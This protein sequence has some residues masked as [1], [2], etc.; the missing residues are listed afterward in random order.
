MKFDLRRLVRE[1]INAKPDCKPAELQL[2]TR[3]KFM[4]KKT[5]SAVAGAAAVL[6]MATTATPAMA[7]YYT[8]VQPN[9]W[10]SPYY[11]TY[12]PYASTYVNPYMGA[13]PYYYYNNVRPRSAVRSAL[14]GAAIGAGVG[15]GVSLLSPRHDRRFARNVGIGAGVGAGVGLL[16]NYLDR[17]NNNY[18]YY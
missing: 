18:W 3:R 15:L 7:Q 9:T 1:K 16:G 10:N 6:C 17:R 5:L 14:K 4:F 2:A 8:Y 11:N 13:S 12:S